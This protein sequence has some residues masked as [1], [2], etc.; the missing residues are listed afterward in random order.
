MTAPFRGNIVKPVES[1]DD[2]TDLLG[3][4]RSAADGPLQLAVIGQQAFDS[5]DLPERGELVI[6]RGDD[7]DIRLDDSGVSRR[8]AFQ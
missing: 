6:G 7:A 4:T 5:M 2:A 1:K 3:S 8:H